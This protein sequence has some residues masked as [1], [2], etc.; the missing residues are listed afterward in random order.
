M[1]A[2]ILVHKYTHTILTFKWIILTKC[3]CLLCVT[4]FTA[5]NYIFAWFSFCMIYFLI[6]LCVEHLCVG[7]RGQKRMSGPQELGLQVSM[8]CPT[9]LS[10]RTEP[11][12][13]AKVASI[14]HSCATSRGLNFLT[15]LVFVFFSTSTRKLKVLFSKYTLP[16][17]I[18]Y[19]KNSM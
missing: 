7:S 13:L 4:N 2:C 19:K 14:L 6:C 16:R 3:V 8:S 5:I 18:F 10:T 15:N 12:S 1:C 9:C 17:V 11:R